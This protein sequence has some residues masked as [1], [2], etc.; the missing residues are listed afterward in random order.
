MKPKRGTR[1]RKMRGFSLV[2][3]I[4]SIGIFAV[5]SAGVSAISS[6]AFSMFGNSRE[7]QRDIESAQYAVNSL[8][9][10]LRT[11][12]VIEAASQSMTFF[13]HSTS[14]CFGYRFD[15]GTGA[16]QARWMSVSG[17]ITSVKTQCTSGILNACGSPSCSWQN[18]TASSGSSVTGHFEATP[19]RNPTEYPPGGS[20]G[21]VTVFVSVKKSP[22][23]SLGTSLQSTVSLRD[24]DYAAGSI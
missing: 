21:R 15:A 9:K 20:V 3:L 22:T 5:I 24:Y 14:R 7:I 8:S 10:Y 16:I 18:L 6:S 1:K 13:D 12:T 23:S 4:V 2:E 19:S 11:S 17:P